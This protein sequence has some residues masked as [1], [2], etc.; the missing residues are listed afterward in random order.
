MTTMLWEEEASTPTQRDRILF[1]IEEQ[2]AA[3]EILLNTNEFPLP[4]PSPLLARVGHAKILLTR[5]LV[6]VG[7]KQMSEP[8]ATKLAASLENTL[9]ELMNICLLP[10]LDPSALTEQKSPTWYALQ[11]LINRLSSFTIR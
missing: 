10:M 3:V 5:T 1:A 4:L 2:L 9:A 11:D 6:V 8:I 7:E